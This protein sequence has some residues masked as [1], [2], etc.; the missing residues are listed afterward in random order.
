VAE[1]W[2]VNA[3][4]LILLA[5]VGLVELVPRLT[6]DLVIPAGVRA[7]IIATGL[8]DPASQWL[9]CDG[10]RWV[11]EIG[12]LDADVKK[13]DLGLGESEV[14][15]WARRNSSFECILDDREA[16]T[17]AKVLNLRCRGSLGVVVKAKQQG[18]ISEAGTYIDPLIAA[19]YFVTPRIV[20]EARLLAGEAG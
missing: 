11:R 9:K 1:G 6:D 10:A 18:L 16:R 5:K 2:V 20:R 15:T 4:P 19:G 7:E 8:A 12:E 13:K 17:F 14:L 3:S